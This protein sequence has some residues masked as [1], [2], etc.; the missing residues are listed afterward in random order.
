MS[1][2]RRPE[3]QERPAGRAAD[4]RDRTAASA[5]LFLIVA[6]IGGL[7]ALVASAVYVLRLLG[8]FA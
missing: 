5:E 7:I 6:T 3:E 4:R 1:D 8:W 2:G